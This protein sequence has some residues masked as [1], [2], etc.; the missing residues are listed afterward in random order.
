M[1][2]G[3]YEYAVFNMMDI[4]LRKRIHIYILAY[5]KN[6]LMITLR[7]M[8]YS[9]MKHLLFESLEYRESIIFE[10]VSYH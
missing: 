7:K 4:T 9:A 5:E 8:R 6:K 10:L 2:A 1:T 3:R